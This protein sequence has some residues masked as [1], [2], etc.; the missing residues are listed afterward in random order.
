MDLGLKGKVAIV[1]GAGSGIG[2]RAAVRFA[3]EGSR[4]VLVDID[5]KGAEATAAEIRK[6]GGE[7]LVALTDITKLDQ[8]QAM[9]K[10]TL[11]AF[12]QVGVLAN[13]AGYSKTHPFMDETPDYWEK[14]IGVNLWGVIHCSYAALFP[15]RE[16][17]SGAIV[18]VSSDAGR[19]G[20]LGETVYAG[21]KGGVIGFTKSLARETARFG[22]R[23][24]CIC[25]GPTETPLLELNRQTN[26]RAIERMIQSIALRRVATTDEQADAILYLVSDRASYITGQIISVS[27]GLTFAG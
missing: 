2:Q 23:V 6:N 21:A 10:K 20:S 5:A 9:V 11:D 15:M 27:G 19:V 26:P 18:S 12:G 7:A 3:Q 17:Q 14:V 16:R 25:P 22:V 8:V 13:V 4:V 1:T 24:N